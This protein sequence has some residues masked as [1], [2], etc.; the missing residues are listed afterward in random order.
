[1][2]NSWRLSLRFFWREWQQGQW[3]VVFFAV[4]IAVSGITALNFYADRI[5]LGLQKN[6]AKFLG[7]DLVINSSTPIPKEWTRY[8][9]RLAIRTA[10][11]WSYPTVVTAHDKMQLVN[12][13]AVSDH[14]PLIG[15]G[16]RPAKQT[17]WV[18]SRLLPLLALK[19]KDHLVIGTL[20]F[21][22][23]DILKSNAAILDAGWLIAPRVMIL[24]SDALKT[25]TVLDGSRVDF[26]LLLTG[27]SANIEKFKT[28]IQPQ[29]NSQQQLIDAHHQENRLM[30]VVS[31][32]ENFLQLSLLICLSLCSI[33]MVLSIQQYL[34][35]HYG[36]AALLRSLGATQSQ[37]IQ[38]YLFKLMIVAVLAGGLGVILGYI[39][40]NMLAYL[41]ANYV[42]VPL[43]SP[44]LKPIVFGF[45]VGAGLLF[46][47]AYPIIKVLPTISPL[48]L[49]RNEVSVKVTKNS[50]YY[51]AAFLLV[52]IFI[53]SFTG[54][55]LL[56]LLF[57]NLFSVAIAFLYTLSLFLLAILKKILP[58]RGVWRRGLSQLIQY[59]DNTSLLFVG[60][61][62]TL[63]LAIMLGLVRSHLM[64]QWKIS[65]ASH[66][67]NYFAI[68]IA[69]SDLD[70]LK[71]LFKKNNIEFAGIYPIIRGRLIELNDEPIMQVIP[72]SAK[73]HNALHR[74]LNL[75]WMNEVPSDNKIVAGHAWAAGSHQ[76]P[77]ISVEKQL[78]KDLHLQL[79]DRLTF[80]IGDKSISAKIA[81]V[82]TVNWFSFRP[83]FFVIF[84]PGVIEQFP[85]TY[86]TSFYLPD[87]Q[88]HVLNQIVQTFPN[89]TMIDV[90]N[91][92]RQIQ[93][94]INKITYASQYLLVFTLGAAL[95]VLIASMQSSLAERRMSY[96]LWKVLGAS[97]SYIRQSILIELGS[98]SL[99]VSIFAYGFA[100]GFVYLVEARFF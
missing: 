13:L 73:E 61:T 28:W 25:Q 49:W 12:L 82:R 80:Q 45:S 10:E 46:V 7:G 42:Q 24:L 39:A 31:Q 8:A 36:Y 29:L 51:I 66:T 95:L 77:L 97:Q 23:A 79:G 81:N 19:L 64:D 57:L 65:F 84:T 88:T 14:Y 94:M 18:E 35:E 22:V 41:F 30:N 16:L 55:S 58:D 1:M 17:V 96:Q 4:L 50:F 20:K 93:D 6:N 75:T 76:L 74:E 43:P 86:M 71:K 72:V 59:P 90:A 5:K 60:F 67:P 98:L 87:T 33:A 40:Q 11:V 27:N 54:F 44:S 52:I 62:L 92:L 21:S 69:V 47:F 99:I 32:I 15:E 38:H 78:A 26:R 48:F 53:Y 70:A 85:I 100:W 2:R 37:I 91:L 3:F 56:T 63:M 9:E 34:C 83:N 68:N 89:I